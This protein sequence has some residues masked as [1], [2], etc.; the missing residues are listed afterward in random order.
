MF[1][2]VA[3]ETPKEVTAHCTFRA[4][5]LRPE[6]WNPETGAFSALAVTATNQSGET[7][8]LHLDP[9]GSAFVVFRAPEV[10]SQPLVHPVAETTLL[11]EITGRW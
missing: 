5:G 6:L 1:V 3:N 8:P 10:V 4:A 7:L 2:E 11:D 9:S